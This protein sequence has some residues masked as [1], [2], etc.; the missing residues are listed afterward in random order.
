[1]IS[2]YIFEEGDSEIFDWFFLAG[3]ISAQVL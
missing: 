2:A 3:T 1:M